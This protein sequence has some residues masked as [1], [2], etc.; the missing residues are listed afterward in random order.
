M[1]SL[2]I[3]MIQILNLIL[4]IC[5]IS[6]SGTAVITDKKAA[7]WVDGRYHL[8]ADAQTDDNWLVMKEGIV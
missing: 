4:R 2:M 5:T 3:E 7:L 1:R 6:P 8:Q